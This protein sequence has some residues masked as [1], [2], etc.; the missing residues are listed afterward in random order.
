MDEHI[1]FVQR[2]DACDTPEEGA[3]PAP[4]LAYCIA[5]LRLNEAVSERS[6]RGSETACSWIC[7]ENRPARPSWCFLAGDSQACRG[8]AL[9]KPNH[10]VSGVSEGTPLRFEFDYR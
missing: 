2:V 5:S 7:E 1:Y 10:E 9:Q 3:L 4:D 6:R 8:F